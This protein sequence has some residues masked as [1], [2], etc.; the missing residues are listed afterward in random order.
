M[1]QKVIKSILPFSTLSQNRVELFPKET[2]RAA[3]FCLAELERA[4]GGGL[5][6][7]QPPEKLVFIAEVCYPFW[8]VTLDKMGLLFDGLSTTSHPLTYLTV[9]D[10]Q[11]FLDSVNRSSRTRQAYM[12]FLSENLNYFQLSGN[13]ERKVIDGLITDPEF[14]HE[15]TSYL[16]K[17][18]TIK[19]SLPDMVVVSPT[20]DESSIFSII[21]ELQSLKSKFAEEVDALYTSMK[22]ISAKT[23]NFVKVTRNEIKEI[24]EKFSKEIE[25]C[26]ASIAEKVDEIRRNYDEK[27]TKFSKKVQKE[28][29]NLRKGK[30]KLEK[31]NEQ[32]VAEIEHCEAETKTHAINK[33]SIGERKWREERDKLKKRLSENEAEIK[34]LVEKIKE[35][36]DEKKIKI[37]E[38]KSE[39]D[40]KI[41]EAARDLV[42]IESSRD[43]K[44][45]T[46]EEEM[47]K[48]EEQTSSIIGQIDE[49]A[50]LREASIAEFDKLGVQQKRKKH[51]L[52]YMPFYLVCFQF[53]LRKRYV[54]FPP[55][56]VDSISFSVK[57]KGALG[58]AKIK[59]LLQPRSKTIVSLLNKFPLLM[60][61]NAVFNREMN[62]A[63]AKANIL[64]TKNLRESI[65]NGLER[66]RE[67]GWFSEKEYGSFSQMLT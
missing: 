41:K 64:R 13:E 65:R 33:D 37:F 10:V 4:K 3:I 54:H 22:F 58:K 28:L 32:L 48:L 51:K 20:L 45:R 1:L 63:C 7:K 50:K 36:K 18:T 23:G 27:V 67:E 60:Q 19:T 56:I 59:Q 44:I 38:L 21:E 2:E 12:A 61:Q 55:S 43:A 24:E 46:H 15:F 31:T 9:P 34:E 6:M 40:T 52:I 30:I 5:V 16:S 26:D 14:L 29:L 57:F 8:L 35:I 39:C 11:V 53:K 25:E 17:A 47:Q 62:E 42:E 66:I 49:L